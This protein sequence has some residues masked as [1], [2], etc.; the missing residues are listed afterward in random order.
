MFFYSIHFEFDKKVKKLIKF[1]IHLQSFTVG[2]FSIK[3]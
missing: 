1:D 2:V 3:Y